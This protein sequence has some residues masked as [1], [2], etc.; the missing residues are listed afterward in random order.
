M[1]AIAATL[2]SLSTRRD[3]GITK[4]AGSDFS[5]YLHQGLVNLTAS[6]WFF[7]GLGRSLLRQGLYQAFHEAKGDRVFF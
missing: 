5:D 6:P 2:S 4:K 3:E 1:T 7:T